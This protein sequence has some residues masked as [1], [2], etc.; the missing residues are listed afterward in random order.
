MYDAVVSQTPPYT[1]TTTTK[2]TTVPT[3]AAA[4]PSSGISSSTILWFGVGLAVL[5]IA[6]IGL[7]CSRNTKKDETAEYRTL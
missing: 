5:I 1:T 3:T 6:F 2:P 4:P 7:Y